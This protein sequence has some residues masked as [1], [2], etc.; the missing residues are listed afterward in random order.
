MVS[1]SRIDD[2]AKHRVK[3]GK[4]VWPKTPPWLAESMSW[5]RPLRASSTALSIRYHG[6]PWSVLTV[7]PHGPCCLAS[8]DRKGFSL[9]TLSFLVIL[10]NSALW[11]LRSKAQPIP[12]AAS[13]Y[14]GPHYYQALA[15]AQ[16]HGRYLGHTGEEMARM[17]GQ[18][19]S[20][21]SPFPPDG[22]RQIEY[23]AKKSRF[24]IW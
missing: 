24:K 8:T 11:N 1:V 17:G 10:T 5:Q 14:P 12:V 21:A 3:L 23:P 19:G 7:P 20:T 15:M 13:E 2:P 6:R 22:P 4:L 16:Q 18:L 9:A